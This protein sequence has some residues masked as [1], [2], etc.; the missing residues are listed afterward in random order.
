MKL[1]EITTSRPL[2]TA[3]L[4]LVVLVLGIYGLARLPV[5]FLPDV[6][7]PLIKVHIWWRGAT[8]EE[9]DR[10]IAD[11]VERQLSTVDG[12][13]YLE[14]SSIEGMYTLQVNFRYGVDVDVAYQDALAAMARVARDLPK[15]IDPPIVIKADPSQLP[16]MQLTVSSKQWDPVQLRDWVDTW[17]SDRLLAV[18]GVAGTEVVG[19][20]K[21]EIRVHLDPMAIERHG[22]AIDD[23]IRR[24]ARENV[25]L[26]AGRVTAGPREF[27]ARTVG[28]FES[29][30]DLRH[31]VVAREG[32]ARLL[33]QDI[34]SVEDSHEEVR[35]ITRVN[36]EPCVKLS[37]LKQADANAVTVAGSMDRRLE[38]LRP[39]LP[40]DV[41]LGAV[42]NQAQYVEDALK[43]VRN[44][45]L[46]A[47]IMIVILMAL[48][49]GNWRQV[50]AMV[51]ALPF[52]LVANFALM[53]LL[54]LSINIFSVG[55]LIIAIA[56]DLDNSIIVI[57]NITRLRRER[58]G[59][60]SRRLVVAAVQ[61][62]GPAVL[63]STLSF[64]ALFLPFLLVPGLA[65]LLFRE[66][67]LVI[68]GVMCVSLVNALAVTPV[69]MALLL[70]KAPATMRETLFERFVHRVTLTY[71]RSLGTVLRWRVVTISVFA[72]LL[73]VAIILLP[74]LGTEFLPRM[75]DGR[76]MVKVRLPT[77]A[78]LAQTDAAL[79]QIEGVLKG[80]PLIESAFTMAGGKVWGLYSYE[81]ANEGELDLQLV[82]R[83]RRSVTTA[84]FT[85]RLTGK[86]AAAPL[87]AGKAMVM[88]MPVKGI[89]RT[90]ESQIEVKLRG[91]EI[92]RLFS[93]AQRATGLMSTAPYL[94][95]VYQSLDMNKPEYQ[96][97][98]DRFRA[99]ELGV[100]VADVASSM[101]SLV[102]G[103][104]ASRFRDG[105]EYYN[106]R[107]MI[108]E[109]MI[110]SRTT[111][112]DIPLLHDAEGRS[113]RVR[114]VAQVV[115]A[116]GPVEIVRE[117]QIKQV[118]IRA[119]PAGVSV[120]E[121]VARLKETLKGLDLPVGYEL[122]YGGQ[123]QLMA[124]AQRSLLL[125][126]AFALFFAFIILVVQFN[127]LPIPTI[128][129]TTVP[130]S[131]AGLV[132]MLTA[133]GTPLG[134][135]VVIGLLVIV[136]AHVTEGVLLLTYAEEIGGRERLGPAEAVV[137]A[138]STRFR[139]RIMTALG[140]IVGLLPIA[141]N[142]EGGSD[143]LQP[144][145][146][147]AVG[148]L[149][150]A[151]AVALYLVP[152]LYTLRVRRGGHGDVAGRSP[153][154]LDDGSRR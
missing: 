6:T 139:P 35:I 45:A 33:L 16:V 80:D 76:V 93:L 97:Q 46:E 151:I 107:L 94:E 132:L 106:I 37:I 32:A 24:L 39:S 47:A 78:A 129:L 70:R 131:L 3:A 60:D 53:S 81:I 31:V 79:R 18:P 20:L 30:D 25:E 127:R 50:T 29:L 135:T 115:D 110:D 141:L 82:P 41:R 140:V 98:V 126:L 40:G 58:P 153:A 144:M 148:G 61:E 122:K 75:D 34:A 2:S 125:V 73:A 111:L 116:V 108:P 77:G 27:I 137:K 9:I 21:R 68:A 90:G 96:V 19:G 57:E 14:S 121:A 83:G 130:F 117:D 142:L 150:T 42:E 56:V 104:I 133:T 69:I 44:A 95:N 123:A 51:W 112:E 118:V 64:L 89:R 36:G 152:V 5:D 109:T 103:Q 28:E 100:S 12:L 17:L 55:G 1:T 99:A 87:P 92:S 91:V 145:A 124:D 143:L 7:Y 10:Q 149:V 66:L 147:A 59:L 49:L 85:R 101:Q 102:R 43:G 138:A 72:G 67:V 114:D 4:V 52:T 134:T 15:D 8:P 65:S 113:I 120:G 54:G 105:D 128:I 26:S 88:Q 136:A 154:V 62:V 146:L 63:A 23:V 119:D 71:A 38:E 13:D 11:P 22:L 86:L 48:F 74:R 84:E